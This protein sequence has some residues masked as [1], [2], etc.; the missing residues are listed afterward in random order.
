MVAP[1]WI[2]LSACSDPSL[3]IKIFIRRLSLLDLFISSNQFHRYR[4]G[5]ADSSS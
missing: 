1:I 3:Q 5:C 2:A 4:A